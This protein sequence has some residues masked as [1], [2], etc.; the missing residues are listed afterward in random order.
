MNNKR[1]ILYGPTGKRVRA[2]LY[3]GA[4]PR[5]RRSTV[6]GSN[7]ANDT[8]KLLSEYDRT[9]LLSMGRYLFANCGTL[10]AA[11]LEIGTYSVGTA[12]QPIYAGRDTA[13]GEEA[14][15]W[16]EGWFENSDVRGAPFDLITSL[17]LASV[18]ID[19]DGDAACVLTRSV[20]GDW[21]FL[22]WI[23]SHRIGSRRTYVGDRV[24]DGPYQGLRTSHGVIFNAQGRSV[25]I[26]VLGDDTSG[27]DDRDISL[28]DAVLLFEPLWFDQGRG[29]PAI[30][31]A[32]RDWQDALDIVSYEKTAIKAGSSIALIEDNEVGSADPGEVQFAEEPTEAG[33]GG[34]FA[35]TFEEGSVRYFRAKSGAGLKPFEQKRPSSEVRDFLKNTVLR[36]AFAGLGWPFEFAF[37]ASDLTGPAVR[38]I[39]GKADRK[40]RARQRRLISLWMRVVTYA[41]A[42]A[43]KSGAISRSDDW[44]AWDMTLPRMVSIDLGRDGRAAIE[45]LKSGTTTL[46]EITGEAGLDWRQVI[47]Q[48]A[49][50]AR[51]IRDEAARVGVDPREI[52]DLA[53]TAQPATPPVDGTP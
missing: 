6:I 36:S 1:P 10:Q 30:S 22:Q 12:F 41:L 2:G 17:F 43:M 7:Y 19:R 11:V 24:T 34:V 13:W 23:P 39:L 18:A 37:D 31:A 33:V 45:G 47:R 50:E 27:A 35:E 53:L 28:R 15:T 4:Q 48:K 29:I 42:K 16:L 5:L 32:V 21:P 52:Q 51:A 38:M 9:Q 40:V 20:D 8:S 25:A 26:R 44:L 14:K 3:E 49:V 46:S